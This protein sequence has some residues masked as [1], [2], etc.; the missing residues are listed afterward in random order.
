RRLGPVEGPEHRRRDG[1][2]PI[3]RCCGRRGF[4]GLG[5]TLRSCS[6][7]HSFGACILSALRTTTPLPDVEAEAL[8][9]DA[10]LVELG[11]VDDAE[12]LAD[13]VVVEGHQ[14][15]APNLLKIMDMADVG[16]AAGSF[17]VIAVTGRDWRTKS[18][19]SWSKAHSMS[20]GAPK[21]RSTCLAMSTRA[22]IASS[23]RQDFL[24]RS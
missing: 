23:S 6:R 20:C 7:K 3:A 8:G 21:W 19:P 15:P 13:V 9:L 11:L 2:A 1:L 22:V 5:C 12:D 10:E 14:P 16:A 18:S 24:R 4:G 17:F